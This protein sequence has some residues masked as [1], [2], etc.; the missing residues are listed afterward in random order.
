MI[1]VDGRLYELNKEFIKSKIHDKK[2]REDHEHKNKIAF[3]ANYLKPGMTVIDAGACV[4]EF[5]VLFDK[6][7]QPTGKVFAFEP[8]TRNFQGLIE[9]TKDGCTTCIRSALSDYCGRGNLHI[10][11]KYQGWHYLTKSKTDST[12]D[13]ITGIDNT[14]VTYID[15]FCKDNEITKV[16]LIKIDVEGQDLEVLKGAEKTIENNNDIVIVIELHSQERFPEQNKEILE[17]FASKK[18]R[19]YDLVDSFK[20]ITNLNY[21]TSIEILAVRDINR[22]RE[23]ST[24]EDTVVIVGVLDE[25][26]STNISIAKAFLRFGFKI[27]PVNYRSIIQKYEYKFFEN[28]LIHSVKRHKPFLT[29]FCKCN[30]INPNIILECNKYTKTWLWNM[31]PIQTIESCPEVIQHAKNANFASC[32][33]GGVSEYFT[34]CGVPKCCTI[35]DGLDYD[36]FKPTGVVSEYK[37][38]ISFIG[39]RTPER[40]RIKEL[41]SKYNPKFYGQGYTK[42]IYNREFAQVCSNSDFMLSMGTYSDA[43]DTFSNRLLR[44]LG[45]G[46]CVLH[47]DPTK[48]LHKYFDNVLFFSTD[49]ELIDHIENTSIERAGE[50]AFKGRE[51]VLNKY[52]WEHTVQQILNEVI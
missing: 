42:P 27:L 38:K 32:T 39:S 37:T 31:D 45:C 46:T 50:L 17:F 34:K 23:I 44:Y 28:L 3:F 10:H 40:D 4:G 30:G 12:S 21:E 33:G 14:E 9:N 22:E 5:T 47:Y 41:L 36:I 51:E 6:L 24:I 11:R 26:G 18:F 8:E 35:F 7:V 15:K 1:H 48:T 19:L 49:D 16:D 20:E 25:V 29:V 43:V 13:F 52:T 2:Y